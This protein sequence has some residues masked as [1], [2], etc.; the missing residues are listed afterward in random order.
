M[1]KAS[2]VQKFMK[3][4]VSGGTAAVL[5]IVLLYIFTDWLGW[6]Y[7]ISSIIA[8]IISMVAHFILQK[9]WVFTH[10][11]TDGVHIQLA[12]FLMLSLVNLGINSLFMY[13][14][15]SV[16]GLNYLVAQFIIRIVLAVMNYFVY[17]RL[18]FITNREAGLLS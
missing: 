8:F 6:W 15:V 13:A 9:L 2:A 3:F 1:P 16:L 7:L 11:E 17:E 14:A 18:I 5:S 10:K 12:K 4:A